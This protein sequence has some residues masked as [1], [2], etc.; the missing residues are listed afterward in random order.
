MSPETE[1]IA[2]VCVDSLLEALEYL[3]NQ[4]HDP[5]EHILSKIVQLMTDVRNLEDF[6]KQMRL[7]LLE[8]ADVE[9]IPE[10]CLKFS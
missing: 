3:L 8:Y 6:H 10:L 2:S 5:E 1:E 4:N 7:S 9:K